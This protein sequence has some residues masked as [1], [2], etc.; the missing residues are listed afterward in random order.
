MTLAAADAAAAQAEYARGLAQVTQALELAR[1]LGNPYDEAHCLGQTGIML[2]LLHS[3]VE[4]DKALLQTLELGRKLNEPHVQAEALMERGSLLLAGG[5]LAEA[6]ECL[7]EAIVPCAAHRARAR[8][9]AEA[10][11]A[12]SLVLEKGGDYASALAQYKE[13]H[14]VREAELAGSRKHCGERRPALARLPGCVAAC[15]AVPRTRRR[16]SP[17][18]MRH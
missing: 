9:S 13:F 10:C 6:Q 11:E 15:V 14:A 12:L 4:A 1:E 16:S 8:C 5:R 3:D 7:S 2:R 18:T 17:P